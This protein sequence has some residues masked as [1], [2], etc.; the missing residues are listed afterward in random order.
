MAFTLTRKAMVAGIGILVVGLGAGY[1]VG[2]APGSGY[3]WGNGWMTRQNP[4]D[5]VGR[6]ARGWGDGSG[7]GALSSEQRRGEG[8]GMGRGADRGNCLADECL[9]VDGLNYPIGDLSADAVS[10]IRSAIDD[11]YKA[12]A[13]YE[14]VMGTYGRVRPFVMIA[15]SEEQ[16][17]SSLKAVFD[18][19]G[20][21]I[22][23]NPY[24][25]KIQVPGSLQASCQAGVD[26]EIANAA[27]YR[28]SLLPKVSQ[29]PD[30]VSVFTNLMDA[31]QERHLPAF[32]RCR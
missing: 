3:G 18:K 1:W 32:E 20:L 2:R 13:T 11:E 10:A 30:I 17:I 6:E 12:L 25:G 16:H 29:H 26:A 7:R 8:T 4:A 5:G 23:S 15:R 22:P 28:E 24:V 31:S 27:L 9:L 21:D 19:Y 14:A